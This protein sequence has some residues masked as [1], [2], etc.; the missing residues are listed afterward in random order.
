MQYPISMAGTK[1]VRRRRRIGLDPKTGGAS[2]FGVTNPKVLG[3]FN[4]VFGAK[5]KK[6]KK[7]TRS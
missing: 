2:N 5:K 1:Q 4:S 7:R 3:L 6:K